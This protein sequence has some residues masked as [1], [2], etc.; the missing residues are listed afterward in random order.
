MI[1][2]NIVR[3]KKLHTLSF[4]FRGN[5]LIRTYYKAVDNFSGLFFFDVRHVY[6]S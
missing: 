6:I 4:V 2:N 1:N 5:S 3:I